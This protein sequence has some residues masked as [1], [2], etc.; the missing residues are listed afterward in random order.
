MDLESKPYAFSLSQNK[1]GGGQANAL[2]NSTNK[3]LHF[4]LL[5]RFSLHF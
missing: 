2:D 3:A 4:H 5:R 1:S